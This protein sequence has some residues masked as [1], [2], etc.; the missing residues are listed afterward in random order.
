MFGAETPKA[1]PVTA[2]AATAFVCVPRAMGAV[3]VSRAAPAES[4]I[5]A[6]PMATNAI[7]TAASEAPATRRARL[8]PASLVNGDRNNDFMPTGS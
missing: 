2:V 6:V 5:P 7:P 4:G 8:A 3:E 1:L